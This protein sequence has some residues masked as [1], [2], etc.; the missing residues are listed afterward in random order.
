MNPAMTVKARRL[1]QRVSRKRWIKVV[2]RT[3][4]MIDVLYERS[5]SRNSRM[6]KEYGIPYKP[7]TR[8]RILV[9][10]GSSGALYRR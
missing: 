4:D 8:A 3:L 7:S 1:D 6:F 2:N 10:K 5:T 9:G